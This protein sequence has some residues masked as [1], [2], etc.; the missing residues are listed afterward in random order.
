[1][2]LG[3]KVR[4]TVHLCL[5][6]LIIYYWLPTRI[7]YIEKRYLVVLLMIGVLLSDLFRIHRNISVFGERR[8]ERKRISALSWVAI[9]VGIGFLYFPRY[10]VVPSIVSMALIDPLLGHLRRRRSGRG[11][12]MDD[13]TLNGDMGWTPPVPVSLS[14]IIFFIS[15]LV[16]ANTPFW[17][18]IVLS[19]LGGIISVASERPQIRNIDDDFLMMICPMLVTYLTALFFSLI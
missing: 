17:E 5:A 11:T 8:Y 2:D 15:M 14:I 16:L 1:M 3:E 10:I 7:L 12:G 18:V 6:G 4:R 9:G 13:D 19:I